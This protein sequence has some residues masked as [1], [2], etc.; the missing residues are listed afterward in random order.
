MVLIFVFKCLETPLRF[1]WCNIHF[2]D[3]CNLYILDFLWHY[4]HWCIR[5]MLSS[6]MNLHTI[7]SCIP[8]EPNPW[9]RCSKRQECFASLEFVLCDSVNT[10]LPRK[11]S[12]LMLCVWVSETSACSWGFFLTAAVWSLNSAESTQTGPCQTQAGFRSAHWI[13]HTLPKRQQHWF[14]GRPAG[15]DAMQVI[16][17][18]SRSRPCF[19]DLNIYTFSMFSFHSTFHSHCWMIWNPTKL[20][21]VYLLS[22]EWLFRSSSMFMI[23]RWAK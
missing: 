21:T 14:W 23:I 17:I 1:H 5:Q 7:S 4:L 6:N 11:R 9:P 13:F 20:N 3:H 12:E 10:I 19:Q 8:W 22:G 16:L 15:A 2:I 18:R